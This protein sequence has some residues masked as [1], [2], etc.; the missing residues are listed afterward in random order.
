MTPPPGAVARRSLRSPHESGP[1][2]C[3]LAAAIPGCRVRADC[4]VGGLPFEHHECRGS[5]GGC[6]LRPHP[7]GIEVCGL[8]C[9]PPQL[10]RFRVL[11]KWRKGVVLETKCKQA[12]EML[13]TGSVYAP[14]PMLNSLLADAQ[15]LAQRSLGQAHLLTER[16]T[17]APKGVLTLLLVRG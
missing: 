9:C 4:A 5:E 16:H 2:D 6:Q 1:R 10:L 11:S 8:S 17:G 3:A 13:W 12:L 7:G 15:E 14:L